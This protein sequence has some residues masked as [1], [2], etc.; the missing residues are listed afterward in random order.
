MENAFDDHIAQQDVVELIAFNDALPEQRR[1]LALAPDAIWARVPQ[2]VQ[3]QEFNLRD[4]L[5][6][7]QHQ[8]SAV[9]VREVEKGQRI[10]QAAYQA[11]EAASQLAPDQPVKRHSGSN[12][13]PIMGTNLPRKR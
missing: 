1:F 10:A 6:L 13:P 5:A 7:R 8:C 11:Y 3:R 4:A 12:W 9:F 2:Q